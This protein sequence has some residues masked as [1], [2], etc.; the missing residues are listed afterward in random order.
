VYSSGVIAGL[1]SLRGRSGVEQLIHRATASFGAPTIREASE[2]GA[3][4]GWS[5]LRAPARIN[6]GLLLGR[7]RLSPG[8]FEG[9]FAHIGWSRAKTAPGASGLI[10]GISC[11]RSAYGGEPLFWS[12]DGTNAVA[13]SRLE[14]VLRALGEP[15]PPLDP[16][17]LARLLNADAPTPA[18]TIHRG[19][20]RVRSGESLVF[21]PAQAARKARSEPGMAPELEGH[22]DAL[23][24]RL[25]EAARASVARAT[26]G[27]R[28]IGVLAGGGVDSSGLL[29]ATVAHARERGDLTVVP[30]SLDFAGPGDDR[31]HMRALETALGIEALRVAPEEAALHLVPSLVVD[32]RPGLYPSIA[33]VASAVQAGRQRG[34]ERVLS[35]FLGDLVLDAPPTAFLERALHGGPLAAAAMVASVA[36]LRLPWRS[37]WRSRVRQLLIAPLV[38]PWIPRPLLDARR[39]WGRN[40]VFPSWAGPVMRAQLHDADIAD[41]SCPTR[42]P[43]ERRAALGG[44]LQMLEQIDTRAQLELMTGVGFVEPWMD[45]EFVG[46]LARLPGWRLA[47]GDRERGLFRHALRG[48]VPDSVRLRPDKAHIE[49]AFDRMLA[50]AGG[51]AAFAGLLGVRR[52]VALGL[53]DAGRFASCEERF[54][55]SRTGVIATPD[56]LDDEEASWM[57]MWNVYAAEASCAF[58]GPA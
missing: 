46:T 34:V 39:R 22:P 8:G 58:T 15:S 38:R 37:S 35:G 30:L 42:T 5:G 26:E 44:K 29:A 11:T 31:P 4:L 21:P 32:A 49:P 1:W 24:D 57:Y 10:E 3:V 51:R 12:F 23:A 45:A 20:M 14:L 54:F 18:R 56:S 52:L 19:I 2:S 53:V 16:A 6:D 48:H 41:Q 40:V 50:A 33:L 47:H 25:W 17:Y 13:S 36:R 7:G 27:V 55:A 9:N 43:A 28:V